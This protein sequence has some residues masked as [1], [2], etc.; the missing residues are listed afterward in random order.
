MKFTKATDK[1]EKSIQITFNSQENL[2]YIEVSYSGNHPK[3]H[4]IRKE[5]QTA[6]YTVAQNRGSSY[7]VTGGTP[8]EL[9]QV[10]NELKS[11]YGLIEPVEDVALLSRIA[12]EIAVGAAQTNQHRQKLCIENFPPGYD[13]VKAAQTDGF[14]AVCLATARNVLK[15]LK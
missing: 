2:Y 3:D 13:V 10:E 1:K 14:M 6:K 4:E 7:T 5:L 11:A 15:L 9:K 8:E 12:I